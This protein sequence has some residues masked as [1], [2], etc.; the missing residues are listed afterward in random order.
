MAKLTQIGLRSLIRK[1]GRHSDGGGLYFR[2][3]GKGKAY[4][5][6]RYRV[7][8]KERE[9]SLGP[10]PELGLGE[11]RDKHIEMRKLV[12]TNKIDPIAHKRALK[13]SAARLN[14]KPSFGQMADQYIETHEQ[15]QAQ[16]AMGQDARRILRADPRRPG[17]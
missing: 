9:T 11:A 2:V 5:V 4:W 1:P 13:A 14:T 7:G 3:L 10:F 17:P 15:P 12:K 8:D 16:A 6:Y